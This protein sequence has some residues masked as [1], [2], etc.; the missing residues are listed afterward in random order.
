[1]NKL[2]TISIVVIVAFLGLKRY[3]AHVNKAPN[4]EY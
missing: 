3:Q 1:M 4:I 2:L